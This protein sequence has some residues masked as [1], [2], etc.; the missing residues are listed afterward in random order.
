[1]DE[2]IRVGYSSFLMNRILTYGLD[3]ASGEYEVVNESPSVLSDML[4]RDEV[5][6]ALVPSIE[7]F[8]GGNYLLLPN[9]SV[10]TKYQACS[11]KLVSSCDFDEMKTVTVD[12]RARTSPILLQILYGRRNN[13]WSLKLKERDISD[14]D[15]TKFKEDAVLLLGDEALEFSGADKKV[16]DLGEMWWE[17]EHLPF[18]FSVWAV[19][20]GKN[21]RGIDKTLLLT[22]NRNLKQVKEIAENLKRDYSLPPAEIMKYL[23]RTLQYDLS[24]TEL[25]GLQTFYKYAIR[26]GMVEDGTPLEIYRS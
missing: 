6:V 26:G 13:D 4:A 18:V 11:V 9:I 8:K 3:N 16:Y 5:D 22:K 24:M 23:G 21:L 2:K 14:I 25:G 19:K 7:Y 10:T 17:L 12:S 1:M 15:M 20:Q